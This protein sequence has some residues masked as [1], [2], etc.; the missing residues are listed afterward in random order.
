MKKWFSDELVA[1]VIVTGIVAVTT[2]LTIKFGGVTTSSNTTD[3]N[4]IPKGAGGRRFL[5]LYGTD[6]PNAK[7]IKNLCEGAKNASFDSERENAAKNI[8][9]I[10]RRSKYASTTNA[11]IDALEDL[12]FKC[13]FSSSRN[14][15]R[16]YEQLLLVADEEE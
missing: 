2:F 7:V 4:Y 5:S 10:A 11:A 14:A 1:N 12:A 9:Q 15:I 13:S 16:K 6:D 3:T 8:Y